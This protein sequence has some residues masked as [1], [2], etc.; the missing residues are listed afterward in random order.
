M[1]TTINNSTAGI[2]T[3]PDATGALTLQT[4]GVDAI[5]IDTSQ[6][7]TISPAGASTVAI[8][9]AGALTINPTAAS[10]INNASIG[11]TTAAAGR[12]TTL[13]AT[14]SATLS[15]SGTVIINPTTAS[16]IDNAS[17]GVTTPLAGSF[18]SLTATSVGT[19]G[20][21]AKTG[22][23]TANIT[24]T[25][26]V[27][28]TTGGNTLASQTATTGATWRVRAFG[29]YAAVTS[30]T[31]RNAQVRPYWGTVALP[32]I[33]PA[34]LT[35]AANTTQWQCEFTLTASSTTAMWTA[36]SLLSRVTSATAFAVDN[37]TPASTTVTAGAQTLDLRFSMSNATPADSWIVQS[38]IF[39]RLV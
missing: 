4:G 35:S 6:N 2:L 39:E 3:T 21:L 11:V 23:Q 33:T 22:G 30:A 36:G 29:Q 20:V 17:I 34:V 12:F 38:V 19:A 13:T 8:S 14:T 26:T 7:V 10:T 32:A 15:P 5:T 27:T 18:T 9:P 1:A 16:T 24:V 28:Y 31:A 37:A 25:N